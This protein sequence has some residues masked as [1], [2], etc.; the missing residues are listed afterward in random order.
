[1]KKFNPEAPG[2][3][4]KK[5]LV[6]GGAG[7]IGSHLVKFLGVNTDWDV[8]VLDALTYAGSLDNLK[9][10]LNTMFVRFIQAD[11]SKAEELEFLKEEKFD[12]I[13]HLA[14]ESHVDRS[15]SDPQVFVKT[16]VN[17][18]VNLLELGMHYFSTNPNFI[19]YHVS[20]DE[21]FGSLELNGNDAFNEKTPYDPKSP[22][23]AS[24]AASD[25]FVRAYH[26]TYGLPVLISN[27]SNNYGTHQYPEKLIPVVIGK[28]VKREPIPIYGNGINKR[29]WLHVEDHCSAIYRIIMKGKFGKTYCIGGNNVL[30]N[31]QLVKTICDIYDNIYKPETISRGLIVYVDDRKGHDLKYAIDAKKLKKKLGWKPS[32]DFTEGIKEVIQWYA[33]R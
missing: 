29:D 6:T 33:A 23:S 30:S 31:N 28:L 26:H 8:H 32:K 5:A 4:I 21:V 9:G 22:Y 24:K 1:M 17:G 7:F 14:A 27:C 18:T 19:F 25:H 11:I 2:R 3:T 20:T 13:I 12:I 16:N 10:D 15:I